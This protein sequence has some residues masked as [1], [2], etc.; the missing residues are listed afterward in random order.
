M[1]RYFSTFI[2]SKLNIIS[3][4]PSYNL[5]K[6]GLAY[7]SF[8]Y[9]MM[10]T[11]KKVGILFIKINVRVGTRTVVRIVIL[12]M[13]GHTIYSIKYIDSKLVFLQ[14]YLTNAN[15]KRLVVTL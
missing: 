15:P 7:I 14:Q 4:N 1:Y 9:R 5:A 2:A 6:S 12:L 3:S 11:I 10:K 8:S 13:I